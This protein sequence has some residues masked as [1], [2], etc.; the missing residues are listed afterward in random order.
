M[1]NYES[2]NMLI[3]QYDSKINFGI[4]ELTRILFISMKSKVANF[5]NN[6][7]VLSALGEIKILNF[8]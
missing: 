1:D 3:A 7:R 8:Y 4:E 6:N 5:Q 2:M